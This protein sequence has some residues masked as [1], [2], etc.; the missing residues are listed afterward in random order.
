MNRLLLLLFLLAS[1]FCHAQLSVLKDINQ[2]A[3]PNRSGIDAYSITPLNG[4]V[5][6]NGRSGAGQE[7]WKSDGTEAGTVLVKD[8]NPGSSSS[9]PFSLINVNGILYFLA[10]NGT[11][12]IEL[13]KSDG[14]EAGTVLVKDIQAGS[15]SATISNMIAAD[16]I[17]FFTITDGSNFLDL[18][19]SDGTDAGTVLLRNNII[20]TSASPYFGH[21]NETL[22]FTGSNAANGVEL[23]KSDGTS[24]GTVLVKD[25]NTG[26]GSSSPT[27]LCAVGNILYFN[28]TD[29]TN[30]YELWK[31]DGTDAG[32]QLVKDIQPGSDGSLPDLLTNVNGTLYFTAS[33]GTI[34]NGLWTSDG[35]EAGTTFVKNLGEFSIIEN[36]TAVGSVLYFTANTSELWK[37]DGTAAGTVTYKNIGSYAADFTNMNGTLYFV[38]PKDLTAGS[39]LQIWKSDGT[40]PG[41]VLVTDI[42]KGT[43]PGTRPPNDLTPLNTTLYFVADDGTSGNELWTTDGTLAGTE[44]ITNI[45]V[46]NAGSN[47]GH[48]ESL[49]NALYFS[50]Y[51]INNGQEL[52]K[53]DGTSAGTALL[54]EIWFNADSSSNPSYLRRIGDLIYFTARD[55]SKEPIRLWKTDGTTAG[56]IEL[57]AKPSD[58]SEIT[59]V[60]NV[61]FFPGYE[62]N[63]VA[64]ELYK[65]DG[66]VTG[67]KRVANIGGSI[68]A[69][70]ASLTT[71]NDKLY[72]IAN[73][74]GTAGLW[75][76]D[77][78]ELN[79]GTNAVKTFTFLKGLKNKNGALYFFADDGTHGLELWKS[80][81]TDAGTVLVKDINPN[82][83]GGFV[84]TDIL[85]FEEVDGVGYFVVND[86]ASGKELWRTDGTAANTNMVLDINPGA[87]SSNITQLTSSNGTLYFTADDGTHGVELWK[88]DGTAGG[89]TM[90][91]DL[92]TGS[93]SA[94]PANLI[95]VNNFLYFT[96]F[97]GSIRT[98]WKTNGPTCSTIKVT[99]NTTV[100]AGGISGDIIA[101]GEKIYLTGY[102]AG[103]GDEIFVH[104]TSTDLPLPAGCRLEQT[105]TFNPL[106]AKTYGDAPFTLTATSD[107][108]LPITYQS[109]DPSIA[110]VS[111]NTVTIHKAGT[112]MIEASQAGNGTYDAADPVEV[113][114]LINK[115]DQTI[116]FPAIA[117][118]TL[119]DAPFTLPGSSTSGLALSYQ[120]TTPA[121]ISIAGNQVTLTEAG[122]ATVV[123]NQPGNENYNPSA[124][125]EQSFCVNP[126]KPT[127]TLSQTSN[128]A[129][130]TSSSATGNQWF[131]NGVKIT[132]EKGVTLTTSESAV[133]TVQVTI[134][135]CT[136]AISDNVDVVITDIETNAG[137]KLTAYPNPVSDK[138]TIMLP[139]TGKKDIAITSAHGKEGAR[140]STL[141][142]SLELYIADYAAGVYTLSVKTNGGVAYLKFVKK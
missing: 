136:S 76:S 86:G 121:K 120:T 110:S 98:L 137:Q 70:P 116:T 118:K 62:A 89:T 100:T 119:G 53:S 72:F 5:M 93:S 96:A 26:A 104:D 68:S 131:K 114:L 47:P 35:T 55:M 3:D 80:D 66:T 8:I 1:T 64:I 4:V 138:L 71:F 141:E 84:S 57:G 67:T 101:I 69:N 75:T 22:Y 103:V 73:D 126:L 48:F 7:L 29:G 25:I 123:A 94:A 95:A 46:T 140:Y 60:G 128:A 45:P 111:G 16:D 42:A 24:A 52:W 38:A 19:K 58:G 142:S 28:A 91:S 79:A 105:I 77:G 32:T 36:T 115:A 63:N 106:P 9:S 83:A 85:Q 59:G 23:W 108:G 109:S 11:E 34:V 33:D 117:D 37:S 21:V 39:S 78:G 14:T 129:L 54:K 18:W 134:N 124:V 133:Y 135:G 12:G 130:L 112:I 122:T 74:A 132:D 6:F 41:T 127:V 92:N 139:G 97:D 113:V 107:A 44:R 81:G 88:S 82:A 2:A 102:A 90:V 125:A 43:T 51:D 49:N 56:T 17:L 15:G 10:N 61:A 87:A 40:E 27:R 30:G 50:A 65:S 31:S 13:W 99:N 20:S